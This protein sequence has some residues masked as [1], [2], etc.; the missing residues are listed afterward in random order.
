MN[1]NYLPSPYAIVSQI[2]TYTWT[3]SLANVRTKDVYFVTNLFDGKDFLT[4][5]EKKSF[6]QYQ[7]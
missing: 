5:I 4:R 6:L 2:T 7:V 1:I 3:W